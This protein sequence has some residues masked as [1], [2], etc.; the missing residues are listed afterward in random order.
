VTWLFAVLAIAV[1]AAIFLAVL[2]LLGE[3]PAVEQDLRPD[4][5]DGAP[6]FDVVVRGYRMDEVD[7]QLE[8][9]QS[10]IDR[11]R[12]PVAD[13]DDSVV[14]RSVSATAAGEPPAVESHVED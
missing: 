3:L 8:R 7:E 6:A 13:V 4:E 11:L 1:L 12:E 10:E 9:L 2:G 5:L 14:A